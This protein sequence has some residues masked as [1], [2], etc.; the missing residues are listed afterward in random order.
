MSHTADQAKITSHAK[1]TIPLRR[2]A[3]VTDRSIPESLY[4][5]VSGNVSWTIV[6][7][8]ASG[9]ATVSSDPGGNNAYPVANLSLSISMNTPD[10][11]NRKVDLNN[12]PNVDNSVSWVGT[13]PIFSGP[14]TVFGAQASDPIYGTW[15]ASTTVY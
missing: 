14:H 7:A 6:S 15:T 11:Q 8:S 2:P 3:T 4:L 5:H 10:Q 9:I 12:V 1:T 13:T